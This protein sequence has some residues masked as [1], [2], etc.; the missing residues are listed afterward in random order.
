MQEVEVHVV[1]R[2][3]HIL[4]SC[5][6]GGCLGSCLIHFRVTHHLSRRGNRFVTLV[7]GQYNNDT[8]TSTL[9]FQIRYRWFNNKHLLYSQQYTHGTMIMEYTDVGYYNRVSKIILTVCLNTGIVT[10]LQ[11]VYHQSNWCTQYI[12]KNWLEPYQQSRSQEIASIVN[13]K[14]FSFS[15]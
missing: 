8:N 14:K 10:N 1:E 2:N 12:N 15:V 6:C 3:C 4:S 9:V 5:M 7:K 13:L 11:Y